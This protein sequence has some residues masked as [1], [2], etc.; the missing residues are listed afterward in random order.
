MTCD[1]RYIV[2]S[3]SLGCWK[4]MDV[5][6]DI[7][8]YRTDFSH[9]CGIESIVI[10][11]DSKIL[12]TSDKNGEVKKWDVKSGKCL[13]GFCKGEGWLTLIYFS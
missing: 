12:F 10:S 7:K 13:K 1:S 8:V 4:K 11:P 5:F 6:D 9:N 3:D 2:T